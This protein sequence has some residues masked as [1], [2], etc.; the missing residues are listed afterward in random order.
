MPRSSSG[1]M[2]PVQPC[3]AIRRHSAAS[4]APSVSMRRRTSAIGHSDGKKPRADFRSISCV[5]VNPNC[6]A[7]SITPGQ[8]QHKMSDDVALDLGRPGLDRIAAGAQVRVDPPAVG[9]GELAAPVQLLEGPQAL[10]RHLLKPLVQ[11]A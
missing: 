10:L 7:L 3:S 8:P 1:K 11:L 2:M 5:S 6:I 9:E 4:Y